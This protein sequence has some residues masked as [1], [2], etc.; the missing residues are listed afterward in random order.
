MSQALTGLHIGV[1][2]GTIAFDTLFVSLRDKYYLA[3]SI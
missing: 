3:L 2:S 1:R